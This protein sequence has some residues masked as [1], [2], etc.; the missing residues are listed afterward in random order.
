VAAANDQPAEVAGSAVPLTLKNG[1][2][3]QDYE[4]LREALR[5]GKKPAAEENG[6]TRASKSVND[7]TAAKIEEDGDLSDLISTFGLSPEHASRKKPMG[8]R[9]DSRQSGH[10]GSWGRRSRAK[11]V[12]FSRD[13]DEV[14]AGSTLVDRMPKF[15]NLDK[16]AA[17][18]VAV[19]KSR[20]NPIVRRGASLEE[21]SSSYSSSD[22]S[23]A[24]N[25]I[26]AANDSRSP[27]KATW[28]TGGSPTKYSTV[29]R[30]LQ[31]RQRTPPPPA[32][33]VFGES[34]T[35][36]GLTFALAAPVP[37][38]AAAPRHQAI[39]STEAVKT[40]RG[41]RHAEQQQDTSAP[42]STNRALAATSPLFG[43]KLYHHHPAKGGLMA[44]TN[45]FRSLPDFS[46]KAN[47]N[48]AANGGATLTGNHSTGKALNAV[49]GSFAHLVL[50]NGNVRKDFSE[51]RLQVEQQ[52]QQQQRRPPI[53]VRT[54][55]AAK[56]LK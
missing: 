32:S 28:L 25:A 23:P 24:V 48:N 56:Y 19:R 12:T 20:Q 16:D 1:G 4:R 11:R 26:L 17:V 55:W 13:G 39:T 54:N 18:A 40:A 44:G 7:L 22:F 36:S 33:D 27:P 47:N 8:N 43:R 6:E 30:P 29:Y 10:F 35:N 45:V 41:G 52:Q 34:I 21:T 5:R 9:S 53:Q 50:G 2:D 42:F 37:A 31:T 38:Y 3:Q 15:S 51:K 14:I 49:N 46:R